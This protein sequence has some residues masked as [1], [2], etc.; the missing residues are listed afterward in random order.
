[1]DPKS[2]SR[3]FSWSQRGLLFDSEPRAVPSDPQYSY[4]VLK[5][6]ASRLIKINVKRGTGG[7]RFL[8]AHSRLSLNH[9]RVKRI[10]KK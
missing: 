3:A 7:K 9:N 1:M 2:D 8:V 10:L 5:W 6:Q 4:S